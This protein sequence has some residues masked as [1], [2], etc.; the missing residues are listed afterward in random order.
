[1]AGSG[2]RAPLPLIGRHIVTG[3]GGGVKHMAG[4]GYHMNR[5][6][7]S[8]IIMGDGHIIRIVGAGCPARNF[9]PVGRGVGPR[10]WSPFLAGAIERIIGAMIEIAMVIDGWGGVRS[11]RVSRITAT[12]G[13]STTL[14]GRSTLYGTTVRLAGSAGW[15]A[16]DSIMDVR[17][18]RVML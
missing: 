18:S 9:T 10:T 17:S 2:V 8:R 5:G 3:I 13:K 6:V 4:P 11:R 16:A 12:R 14:A 15:M 1:M 7:G